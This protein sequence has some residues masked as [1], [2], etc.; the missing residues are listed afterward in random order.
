MARNT[1][2][3]A[4]RPLSIQAPVRGQSTDY[5]R[6][7]RCATCVITYELP[8][9]QKAQCPACKAMAEVGQMRQALL[10]ANN[11]LEQLTNELNRLRPQVDLVIAMRQALDLTGAEDRAFLKSVAYLHRA[12][13]VV[14]LKPLLVLEAGRRNRGRRPTP[15]GF[16]AVIHGREE[17]HRCTS[18]GGLALAQYTQE[19]LAS[20]GPITTMQH[21]MLAMSAH[22]TGTN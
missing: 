3:P 2:R 13:E 20:V 19:G 1:F 4:R 7:Y 9:G 8:Q 18:I 14:T 17:T 22:L 21:L 10:Q 16:V 12:G 11:K 15:N 6:T 5:S